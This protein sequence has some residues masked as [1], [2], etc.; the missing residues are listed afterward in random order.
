MAKSRGLRHNRWMYFGQLGLVLALGLSPLQ[1]TRAFEPLGHQSEL[2]PERPAADLAKQQLRIGDRLWD[3]GEKIPAR[4]YYQIAKPAFD[5]Q[6]TDAILE[7]TSD[8][9]TLSPA[10]RV[11][12]RNT[13][14]GLEQDL[15]NKT[16]ISLNLLTEESPHFIPGRITQIEQ[17]LL[18][19]EVEAATESLGNALSGY[20]SSM[21]LMTY[22]IEFYEQTEQWFAASL[23]ARRF[24]LLHPE[25]EQHETFM[26]LADEYWEEYQSDLRAEIRGN[27]FANF[28]T[29]AIG[30]ALTGSLLGPITALESSVLILEG[31]EAVGS[32][33]SERIQEVAPMVEDETVLAYVRE[34]GDRLTTYVGQDRFNYEFYVVLNEELNAFAL[35]GGKIFIYAGAI[36]EAR[37]ESELAG[38]I[39]HEI[40]HAALSHGFQLV[41]EGN[42]TANITSTL[43]FGRIAGSLIVMN[44]SRD[45]ERQADALGTQ[46]LASSPYAAD[47]L[48]NLT[49]TLNNDPDRVAQPTWLST[50]PG[51]DERVDNIQTQIVSQNYDRY[52]FEGINRH[53]EIQDIVRQLMAEEKEREA[54][55]EAEEREEDE[56]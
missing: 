36:L 45:M 39:S 29:G 43:P 1:P 15:T 38:L 4:E 16:L 3:E 2:Q 47:G 49:V 14:E 37:S 41:T 30:F 33:I 35:P 55:E 53:E 24:A 21:E 25:N 8:A 32:R 20:G 9:E 13:Q 40:A 34:M 28:I 44:H 17:L 11:Y 5:N 22:A 48:Y 26:T 52:T 19:E 6:I 7:P 10:G 50:H 42:L 18:E 23:A 51:I 54:A 27:T 56:D 31:E 12:W 46:I